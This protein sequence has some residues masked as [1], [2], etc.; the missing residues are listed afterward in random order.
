MTR[1]SSNEIEK[2]EI[3]IANASDQLHQDL[4]LATRSP[5]AK[6]LRADLVGATCASSRATDSISD[7]L[8]PSP[9]SRY[10]LCIRDLKG[11]LV[12][13][14]HSWEA[15]LGFPLADLQGEP[16]LTLVH[17]A[18]VW[19][20]HDRMDAVRSERAT[21]SFLNRYRCRDGRYRQLMWTARLFGDHVFGVALDITDG[22]AAR[23]A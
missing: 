2:F 3:L 9:A 12:K 17:P 5:V 13:L 18:D 1:F 22:L 20:T 7:R 11:K 23:S 10:L 4:L 21:G 19:R 15:N 8:P 14:S 16:L 6:P